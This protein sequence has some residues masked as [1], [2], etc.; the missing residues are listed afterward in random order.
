LGDGFYEQRLIREQVAQLTGYRFLEGLQDDTTEYQALMDAGRTFAQRFALTP[1]I[2]LTAAQMAQLTSDIVWL[3]EQT[4]TLADGSTERVLVPQVYVR[5]KPGDIDGS[6][7]L[8]SGERLVMK[9]DPGRG[10]V[11][12]TGTLAG[13]TLVSIT[14]DDIRNLGGRIS[15]AGRIE[16]S[17]RSDLDNLGGTIDAGNA[18]VLKAG[19]D[20][21]IASTSQTAAG[22]Q[23]ASTQLDRLAGVYV[24]NPGGTLRV[25]ADR[26]IALVGAILSNTGAGSSTLVKAGRDISLDTVKTSRS[27]DITQ[28]ERNH[29]RT[30][31]SAEVGTRIA[32]GSGKTSSVTVLA[33][34]DIVGRQVTVQTAAW[35]LC[36]PT[37]TSSWRS[38]ARP[39]RP[40]APRNRLSASCWAARPPPRPPRRA[41]SPSARAAASKA[42]SSRSRPTAPSPARASSSRAMTACWCRR[43]GR[44]TCTRRATSAANAWRSV[45]QSAPRSPA[46]ASPY[47]VPRPKTP[48]RHRATPP[49]PPPSRAATAACCSKAERSRRCAVCRSARPVT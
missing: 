20:I 26:D 41:T 14:A 33:G 40:T 1:G 22:A 47:P 38:A 24:T 39:P 36:T 28:D 32:G 3:V 19:R 49:R 31:E 5:V 12:N 45:W 11:V 17:A 42:A 10:D 30:A 34:G 25:S 8:L 6:G 27:L 43:A 4:V 29:V 21:R 35:S 46:R 13:R 16:A 48:T 7:A 2:A 37:A 44:W 18:V 23:S 9:A 15:S